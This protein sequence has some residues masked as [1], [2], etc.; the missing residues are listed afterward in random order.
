MRIYSMR[1]TFG[2]LEQA[3]LTLEPGLNVIQ[4]PNEW[5]KSTWCAFLIAMLYG[6]DTRAKSTR[7]QLAVKERFL[8]WSGSPMEGSMDLNWQGRDITVQR[9]TNGRIPM[10]EFRAFE[11]ASGLEIPELN[12]E[13]CGQLLLGVEKEVFTRAG[14]LRFSDLPVTED[15]QLRRRLNALVT[16]GD[17]S[18]N[19][20][21]LEQKLKELKNRCRYNRSGLIPQARQQKEQLEQRI[22]AYHTLDAQTRRLDQQVRELEQ[23]I[24]SLENHKLALRHAAGIHAAATLQKAQEAH[25]QARQRVEALDKQ[26]FSM[27]SQDETTSRL[28]ALTQTR[29]A[30]EAIVMQEQQLPRTPSRPEPPQGFEACTAYQAML[31]ARQHRSEL[32][33]LA[34]RTGAFQTVLTVLGLCLLLLAP[35]LYFFVHAVAGLFCVGCSLAALLISLLLQ[36][37]RIRYRRRLWQLTQRYGTDDPDTWV[38]AAEEYATLWQNYLDGSD[39]N[40]FRSIE[41]AREKEALLAKCTTLSGSRGLS[42]A[43]AHWS[44]ILGFWEEYA[45]ARAALQQAETHLQALRSVAIDVPL[46]P[47]EDTLNFS[48]EQTDRLLTDAQTELKQLLSRQGQFRGQLEALGSLEALEQEDRTLEQRILK[49]EQLYAASDLALKTLEQATAQLQRRFAPR[50][51]EAAGQILSRLTQGRYRRLTLGEDFSL[52]MG[53]ENETVLRS[54][55]WRSDGTVDQLYLAVRLAVARELTPGAPLVLDDALVRFDDRRLRAALE[56]LQEEA[57]NKQVILFTCQ[58]REQN[59]L[60]LN[61]D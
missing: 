18:G 45:D 17:E 53:A 38:Q 58:D 5:G 59:M 3:T 14:F 20:Q 33:A 36:Q 39:T 16:T 22:G 37:R 43:L 25:T 41:L 46:A 61:T 13:N 30:L 11:T 57:T 48:P 42:N 10:G 24:R 29:E 55:Q 50:I 47:E 23:Q 4:A 60:I 15:E 40:A 19:G 8:P 26:A 12:A 27:P 2:K 34:P 9:W 51:S 49:L 44:D 35:V 52:R 31:Q 32:E 56:V 1:A 21:L 6:I 28:Q 7:A 54:H